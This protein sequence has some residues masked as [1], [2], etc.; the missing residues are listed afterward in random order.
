MDLSL[1]ALLSGISAKRDGMLCETTFGVEG[2]QT[3]LPFEETLLLS[4]DWITD[5][6]ESGTKAPHEQTVECEALYLV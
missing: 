5:L 1:L 2:R 6:A 4:A 3:L